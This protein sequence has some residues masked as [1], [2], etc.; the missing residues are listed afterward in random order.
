MSTP[1][2]RHWA[3][4]V[5][6]HRG[7]YL[8]LNDIDVDMTR[9]RRVANNSPDELKHKDEDDQNDSTNNRRYDDCRRVVY[10]QT[11]LSSSSSLSS[12]P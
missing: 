2:L 11:S 7:R 6:P 8:R 10:T 12:S 4:R 1:L 3:Q 5:G 9:K